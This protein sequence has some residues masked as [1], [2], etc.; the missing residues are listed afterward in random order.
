MI[1]SP[2]PLEKDFE[3]ETDRMTVP[4]LLLHTLG[5][6]RSLTVLPTP[7]LPTALDRRQRV[8]YGRL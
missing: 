2:H 1:T 4:V 3:F 6:S 5:P 7:T 8:W